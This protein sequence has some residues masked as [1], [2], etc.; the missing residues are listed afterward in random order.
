LTTKVPDSLTTLSSK[1]NPLLNS[2]KHSPNPDVLIES[3][4]KNLDE[5]CKQGEI[6]MHHLTPVE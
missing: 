1:E 5:A 4:Q 6:F 2:H 3:A